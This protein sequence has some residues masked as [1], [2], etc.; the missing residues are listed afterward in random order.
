M[1]EISKCNISDIKTLHKW[2]Q[3]TIHMILKYNTRDIKI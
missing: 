2:Y 1:H 3:N